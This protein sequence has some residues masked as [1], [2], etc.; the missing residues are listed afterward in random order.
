MGSVVIYKALG[1]GENINMIIAIKDIKNQRTGL[2][3]CLLT[4]Q[5]R[6]KDVVSSARSLETEI[7]WN[8]PLSCF[9]DLCFH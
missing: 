6:K 4:L 7:T 8:V 5:S 9:S 3:G 1:N 2:W